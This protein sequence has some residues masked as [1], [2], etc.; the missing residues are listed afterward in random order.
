MCF[1]NAVNGLVCFGLED[2]VYIENPDLR[3]VKVVD[4]KDPIA[5]DMIQYRINVMNEG[6]YPASGV[7]ITDTLP[8][9]LCYV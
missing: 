1:E 7:T 3:I 2:P 9:G 4:I 5:G 6:N 8:A